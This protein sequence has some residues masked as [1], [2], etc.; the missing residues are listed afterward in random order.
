M[1]ENMGTLKT[2][3]VATLTAL[4]AFLGWKGVM[5]LSW[6][7]VMLLDYLS[8]TMAA[9]KDGQWC[10]AIARQGLWHKGGMILVVTVSAIADVVMV[11]IAQYMPLGIHWPGILLP[12]V[13]AWYILTELGSILENAVRLGANVPEWLVK[14]LKTGVE[15]MDA[16]GDN[17]LE[18]EER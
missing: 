9:C 7:T 15:I 2:A 3:L 1:N 11:V 18:T 16:A 17:V 10:S 6:V 14:L 4:G 12:L 5:M 13:L 8:G